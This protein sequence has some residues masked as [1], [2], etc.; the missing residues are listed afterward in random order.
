MIS[1][2]A[3]ALDEAK[4]KKAR[5]YA[6]I[7]R[8]LSIFETGLSLA[9]VLA[10]IFSG[11]SSRFTAIFGWP[12]AATAIVYFL[13][14][15]VGFEIVTLPL[16]YYSGLV[17][18][19][20]YG[21]ST[22]TIKGWAI[23]LLKGGAISL[24]LGAAGFAVGYWFLQAFPDWWWL[25]IWVVVLIVTVIM[26][27]L[28]PVVLIPIFYKMKPLQD[29]DLKTRLEALA[30][31]AGAA[32][33]GIYILDF[34]TRTTAAN[35]ALV[36]AGRTRRI[37]ISDTLIKQY[38]VPEIEVITAHEIGHHINRD[39]V[40]LFVIQSALF[41]V[42]LKIVAVVIDATVVRAGFSGLADPAAL[43]LY[44]LFIGALGFV[45]GPVLNAY[46]RH[47]E[48]QA[49]HYALRLT[50]SPQVFVDSMTRLANQNLAVA[51]PARWEEL[52]F[53]DHPSYNQRV[54]MARQ[55]GAGKEAK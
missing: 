45:I 7:R 38:P 35:A 48:S 17:L 2:E 23:D 9:V 46:T 55:F 50:N 25:L 31:K 22:Q 1:Y 37:I 15:M 47:V 19:R 40:R 53:Y 30:K 20:R 18:P 11:G 28:G 27:I 29:E 36:G 33:R 8:R 6:S 49:D 16:S 21:L 32:V 24:P 13:I 14:F 3:P 39:I 5:E 44:F 41:L 52:F 42:A 34:S 12:A 43:P 10:L 54:A 4:Q 26:S 51:N